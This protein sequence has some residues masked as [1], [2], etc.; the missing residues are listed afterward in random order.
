[1]NRYKL[2]ITAYV[3][4]SSYYFQL[5]VLL[6]F[7]PLFLVQKGL[8]IREVGLLS[9]F[10]FLT[11]LLLNPLI[12][13]LSSKFY[14]TATIILILSFLSSISFLLMIFSDTLLVI[15]L[16]IIANIACLPVRPLGDAKIILG[17]TRAGFNYSSLRL[18]G[19]VSFLIAFVTGQKLI[20]TT[21]LFIVPLIAAISYFIIAVLFLT[22]YKKDIPAAASLVRYNR[23]SS[24]L[25]DKTIICAAFCQASHGV[26]YAYVSLL[27]Q[28][29]GLS[30]QTISLLWI[31][32]IASEILMFYFLARYPIRMNKR[33]LIYFC[34]LVTSLR[35]AGMGYATDITYMIAL[36]LLQSFSIAVT[37]NTL[38]Q[39]WQTIHNEKGTV[40]AMTIYDAITFGGVQAL[41]IYVASFFTI[42]NAFIITALLTFITP[43]ALCIIFTGRSA[44]IANREAEK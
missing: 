34:L 40:N 15:T 23:A 35:W 2:K 9:A 28:N 17:L 13:F 4:Y 37:Q 12:V 10:T 20:A 44:R 39:I 27:W 26:F 14:R 25:N 5:G 1:M 43:L 22:E 42:H 7:M 36:Q 32:G 38:A 18:C 21:D 3:F 31:C 33:L 16:V 19:S 41:I 30:L 11:R 29:M 24:F 8:S 6:G